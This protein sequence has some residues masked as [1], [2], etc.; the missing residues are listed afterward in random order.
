MKISCKSKQR[1]GVTTVEFALVAPILF[2]IIM[3][4]IELS[5]GYMVS[6]LLTNAAHDG[7]RVGS[8]GGKANTDVNTAVT[9]ALVSTGIR[10]STVLVQVNG[11]SGDVSSAASGDDV[12]VRV[13]VPVSSVTWVPGWHYLGTTISAEY[14]LRRE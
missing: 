13:S 4:M 2:L 1:S 10:S 8:L 11:S 6:H 12:T 9:N 14:S 3:G 7:C 5:R